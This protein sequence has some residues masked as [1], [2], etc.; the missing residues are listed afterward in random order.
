MSKLK[1]LIAFCANFSHFFCVPSRNVM[2]FV[3]FLLARDYNMDD[4]L[5]REFFIFFIALLAGLTDSDSALLLLLYV[6]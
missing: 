2:V 1:G 6:R 3:C 5:D 4:I